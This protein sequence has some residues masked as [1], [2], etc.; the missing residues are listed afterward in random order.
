VTP[1]PTSAGLGKPR[2]KR[3][4]D[5]QLGLFAAP[6]TKPKDE[7]CGVCGRAMKDTHEGR[8]ACERG[9]DGRSKVPL[10]TI[11][12]YGP[13]AGPVRVRALTTCG[14]RFVTVGD[15]FD[16]EWCPERGPDSPKPAVWIVTPEGHESAGVSYRISKGEWETV[17]PPRRRRAAS[18]DDL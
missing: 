5:K 1:D 12:A 3:R 18:L 2:R 10:S 8:R 15:E 4:E 16:A 17:D 9:H 13:S 11:K 14:L 7:T 6:E